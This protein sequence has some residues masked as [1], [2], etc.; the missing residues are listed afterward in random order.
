MTECSK[1]LSVEFMCTCA[2]SHSKDNY[3]RPALSCLLLHHNILLFWH[4]LFEHVPQM[5]I[6]L[7][8]LSYSTLYVASDNGWQRNI[9]FVQLHIYTPRKI[10]WKATTNGEQMNINNNINIKNNLSVLFIIII[11]LAVFYSTSH[12]LYLWML[13]LGCIFSWG[14]LCD[15]IHSFFLSLSLI[16]SAFSVL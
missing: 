13:A 4:I 3:H 10:W 11:N 5:H 1:R 8:T 2:F 15:V 16:I 7:F 9:I 14:I 6:M 12:S